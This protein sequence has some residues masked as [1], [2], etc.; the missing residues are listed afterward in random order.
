MRKVLPLFAVT[1][2]LLSACGTQSAPQIQASTEPGVHAS[3]GKQ[4]TLSG[5]IVGGTIRIQEDS[6]E[7]LADELRPCA[8]RRF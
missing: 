8:K 6:A 7:L 4:N 1:A 5:Q 3:S 2:A